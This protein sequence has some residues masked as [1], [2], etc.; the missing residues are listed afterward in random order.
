MS[1]AKASIFG[2]IYLASVTAC[3]QTPKPDT[4]DVAQSNSATNERP[5]RDVT[6][7]SPQQTP[8][9][10]YTLNNSPSQFGGQNNTQKNTIVVGPTP[11]NLTEAERVELIAQLSQAAQQ[12]FSVV[13]WKD[14]HEAMA[15]A[16]QICDAMK[17]A[18]WTM[19]KAHL[20]GD[21]QAVAP[22]TMCVT[23]SVDERGHD[24][25]NVLIE[26]S[27]VDRRTPVF[28]AIQRWVN[29]LQTRPVTG[30]RWIDRASGD[31]ETVR[32]DV[33]PAATTPAP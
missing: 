28:Y 16:E 32:I 1:V 24:G 18:G 10:T 25:V 21:I 7:V 11:R 8:T 2:A 14:S 4:P 29:T 19:V 17:R 5:S 20:G 3:S 22:P 13:A 26:P 9:P 15:Y 23:P 6:P 12:N 27:L 33:G 31:Q 30:G